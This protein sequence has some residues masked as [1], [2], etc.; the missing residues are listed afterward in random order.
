ML[1]EAVDSVRRKEN[2]ELLKQNDVRL[3]GSR[4]LWLYNPINLKDE[5]AEEFPRLIQSELKTSRAWMLKASFAG[6]WQL[7]GRWHAQGY[8][9]KWYSRAVRSRSVK[10][11]AKSLKN[12]LDGLLNYFTHPITNA[13]T[14]GLTSRIQ[15]IKAN[16]RGFRSFHNYRT[17]ILFFCGK[18]KFFPV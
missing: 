17:R 5:R 16:A 4:Q 18:L 3:T 2:K 8:F 14:E 15:E 12:H 9:S 11:A 10:K 13:V 7:E 1:N 6:F